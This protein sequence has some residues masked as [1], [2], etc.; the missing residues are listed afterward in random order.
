V[1]FIE[2]TNI[3]LA[4]L[5][6]MEVDGMRAAAPKVNMI[7]Q[8]NDLVMVQDHQGKESTQKPEVIILPWE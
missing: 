8:K 4:C 1:S 7:C 5:K 2:A 3:M 6:E